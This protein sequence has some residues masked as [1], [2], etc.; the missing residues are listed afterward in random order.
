[1]SNRRRIRRKAAG[2]EPMPTLPRYPHKE[3]ALGTVRGWLRQLEAAGDVERAGVERTGKP[4]RPAVL[5]Q[6]TEQGKEK[7][8]GAP[9]PP[10]REQ[11][12]KALHDACL[13]EFGI[14]GRQFVR[15]LDAGFYECGWKCRCATPHAPGLRALLRAAQWSRMSV[16]NANSRAM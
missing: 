7:A 10:T 6:M 14:S 13:A 9:E 15:R 16:A 2:G 8:A 12:R 5:W 3:A 1:V 11:A 4:G